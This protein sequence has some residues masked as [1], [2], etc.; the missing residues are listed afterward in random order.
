V[1]YIILRS[2]G[3]ADGVVDGISAAVLALINAE[4]VD[5]LGTDT[6]PAFAQG[7]PSGTPTIK[8]VLVLLN[9]LLRNKQTQ[10]A[11]QFSLYEDNGTTLAMKQAVAESVGTLTRD[12]MVTGP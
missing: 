4:V 8:Q 9:A 11:S 3:G 1:T 10:S 5:T 7:S 12:E 2:A 6:L